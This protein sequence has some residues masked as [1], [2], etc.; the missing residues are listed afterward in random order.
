MRL[1][2]D[3]EPTTGLKAPVLTVRRKTECGLLVPYIT[4][5]LCSGSK[6]DRTLTNQALI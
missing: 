1:R 6:R 2:E 4:L 3:V 5:A